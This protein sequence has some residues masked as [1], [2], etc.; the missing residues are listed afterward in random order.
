MAFQPQLDVVGGARKGR[1]IPFLV[2]LFGLLSPFV[3]GFA[4]DD[5]PDQARLAAAQKAFDGRDWEEAARLAEGPA[6]QSSDLDLPRGP[7]ITG[8]GK[9]RR[10]KMA[11]EAGTKKSPRDSRFPVDPA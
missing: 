11:F 8:V 4:Q 9:W 1:V 3:S 10:S 6:D 7:A 5:G 2:V